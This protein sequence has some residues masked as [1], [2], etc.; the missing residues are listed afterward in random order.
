MTQPRNHPRPLVIAL[1]A[2]FA[3]S[4]CG[5]GGS[6]TASS[7]TGGTP[8]AQTYSMKG[9]A[10]DG[11]IP[12]AL[13][14]IT[15]GA[16]LGSTGATVLGTATSDAAGN[17]TVNPTLPSGSV[18][19]FAN[20]VDP[21]N[22]TMV[23]SSYLG[24]S[25]T[26]A[27]A[28]KLDGS[29]VP[30]LNVT[31]VTTAALAVYAAQNGNSYANLSPSSYNQTVAN[32]NSAVVTIAS[33]IKAIGDKLC[34]PTTAVSSTSDLATQIAQKTAA[35]SRATDALTV[36]IDALGSACS[37]VMGQLPNVVNG[38][39][40]Y[41]NQLSHGTGAGNATPLVPPGTYTLEGVAMQNGLTAD[42][43]LANLLTVAQE[44]PA[45]VVTEAE[46]T[47]GSD[48][49]VTSAD[50]NVT[51]QISGPMIAMTL[52]DPTSG[53]TYS[54]Q[55]SVATIPASN[56]SGTAYAVRTSGSY[57]SVLGGSPLLG[58]FDAV[59]ADPSAAPVW[60]GIAA[61]SASNTAQQVDCPAAQLPLRLDVFG[62]NSASFG[63]CISSTPT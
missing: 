16:P 53:V 13:I 27:A 32:Y 14:T 23:M 36:A 43:S 29:T 39:P 54:L 59:L 12:N 15:S 50:G 33:A 62:P 26:L 5:G 63:M 10:V 61:P 56:V 28:A 11:P 40:A 9:S 6:S 41:A 45:D 58:K 1:A 35:A 18:P 52:F 51:G 2:C 42:V 34:T 30:D 49:S 46:I 60:N 57:P 7:S 24:Q 44:L 25:D 47:V 31:P 55:G 8:S 38:D 20:V 37:S 21:N 4:A 22:P 48:G 17:Y 3:L 19:V